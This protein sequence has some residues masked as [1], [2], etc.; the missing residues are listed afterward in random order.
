[1]A[2]ALRRAAPMAMTKRNASLRAACRPALRTAPRKIVVRASTEPTASTNDA[3]NT[4]ANESLAKAQAAATEAWTWLKT[5]WEA[6]E[7]SEKP[8]VVA[9]LIGV[10]VAQI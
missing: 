2:L 9:I 10:I 7:D 5:K 4:V 1:M 6:T 8:A 3:V